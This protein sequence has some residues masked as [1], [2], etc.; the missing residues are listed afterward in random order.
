MIKTIPLY[1]TNPYETVFEATVL[2]CQE[3]TDASHQGLYQV[4]LDQT[5]FFPEQGGQTPD[6]GILAGQQVL[7]VQIENG[8]ISHYLRQP[9]TN[10]S[11]VEAQVDWRYRF[12]NMQQHTGEH[13]FSGLVHSRYGY[14]NVG[15]HLSDN[16]VTMDYNGTL[17]PQQ[18]HELELEANRCIWANVPVVASFPTEAELSTIAYRSKKELDGAIRI[19]TI[20]DIDSC[21]CCA[22]HV[23]TTAQVGIL[24]VM[25]VQ[26]YKGG[27]RLSILCGERALEAFA[28]QWEISSQ[29]TNLLSV[30]ATE[31]LDAIKRLQ[32]EKEQL[33]QENTNLQRNVLFEK[34]NQDRIYFELNLDSTIQREA[35]NHLVENNAGI[36][37][38]F[39]Q[40]QEGKGEYRFIIASAD[41]DCRPIAAELREVFGA[42]GGGSAQMIQGSV[43]A[44]ESELR[45]WVRGISQ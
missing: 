22:P 28:Q 35:V 26:S 36:C 19:V 42:R 45:E 14:E 4:I 29:L 39:S 21:A 41:T 43:G 44:T 30:P 32:A 1:D 23:S 7:D 16:I 24:K 18:V 8:A 5:Q 12:S 11:K 10:D 27:V 2:S 34:L 33:R 38:I 31:H 25:S 15:F 6:K 40:D 37:A 20:G 9:L 3:A 13:I 17:S